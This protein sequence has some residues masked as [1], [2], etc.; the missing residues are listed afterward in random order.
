MLV[1]WSVRSDKLTG[2]IAGG[3]SVLHGAQDF[4][5]CIFM[6]ALLFSFLGRFVLPGA[7]L[8]RRALC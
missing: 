3:L 6:D 1:E 7:G 4:H 8:S 5:F 2:A